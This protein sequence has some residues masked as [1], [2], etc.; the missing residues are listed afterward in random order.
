VLQHVNVANV[1]SDLSDPSRIYGY[2]VWQHKNLELSVHGMNAY[3]GNGGI[4]PVILKLGNGSRRVVEFM[5]QPRYPLG[6]KHSSRDRCFFLKHYASHNGTYLRAF[7]DT[8]RKVGITTTHRVIS[9]KSED[10]VYF[11]AKA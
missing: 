5:P 2:S 8:Y 1:K 9:L 10:L 4:T 7:Q 11:A 6:K 3:R